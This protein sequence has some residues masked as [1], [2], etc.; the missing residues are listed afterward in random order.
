MKDWKEYLFYALLLVIAYFAYQLFT[1]PATV[2]QPGYVT[3]A[4][5]IPFGATIY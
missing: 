5:P 4:Y 2:N 3:K 1:T